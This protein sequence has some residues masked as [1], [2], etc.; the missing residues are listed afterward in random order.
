MPGRIDFTMG[1]NVGNSA[2][3]RDGDSHY[4]IYILGNFSGQSDAAWQQRKIAR[5]DS[6]N[7]EQAM[8]QIMPALE[9]APGFRLEFATLEAFHPDAW[10]QHVQ[11][12][13]DLQKLK[14]NLNNPNTAKQA[15]AKIRAFFPADIPAHP[16]QTPETESQEDMLQRL[17][18]KK[19]ERVGGVTDTLDSLIERMVSPYVSK[20]VDPD[21]QAL[22]QV[23]DAALCQFLQTLLHQVDFQNLEALWRATAALVNE[24]AADRHEFFLVDIS[25]A[26]LNVGGDRFA[27]TL[28]QHIQA[29][30]GEQDVLLVGDYRF[31]DS[32][33]DKDL[34]GFCSR[35]AKACDGRFLGGVE[36]SLLES[37]LTGGA[38]NA[39]NWLAYRREIC[40]DHVMLAAPRFLLRLP[41]GNKRDPLEAFAFEECS[42]IPRANE[43]LWGNPAFLCARALIEAAQGQAGEAGFFFDDVPAFSYQQDGEPKLQPATEVVFNEAQANLLVSQ[44]VMPVIGFHQRR[45]IRLLGLATLA[46]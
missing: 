46:E 2:T 24:E 8:T 23:I 17:L 27:Q 37:L 6:D 9:V 42:N 34:L 44:G 40:A 36:P 31:S 29:G 28:L 13:A 38:E 39:Q 32:A 25:Q 33:D 12:L 20:D 35:L 16:V 41:Y 18:G 7:F 15:A 3:A 14:Q 22:M 4:R 1:F 26:E 19:P 10:L 30:D 5:V 11:L 43:L 21:H 45:G